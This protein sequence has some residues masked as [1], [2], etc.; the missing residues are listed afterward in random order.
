MVLGLKSDGERHV[1]RRAAL[2]DRARQLRRQLDDAACSEMTERVNKPQTGR[3]KVH[4]DVRE[5]G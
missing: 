5:L 4:D 1:K 3:A 2:D